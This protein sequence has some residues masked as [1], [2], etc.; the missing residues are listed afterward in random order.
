MSEYEKPEET[1]NEEQHFIE[2]TLTHIRTYARTWIFDICPP[3][4]RLKINPTHYLNAQTTI[5]GIKQRYGVLM[6]RLGI[7]IDSHINETQNETYIQ[8]IAAIWC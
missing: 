1:L 5:H 3:N 2:S 6:L 8:F 4:F 7:R